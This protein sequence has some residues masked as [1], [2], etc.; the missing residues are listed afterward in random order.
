M[1][2]NTKKGQTG[3]FDLIVAVFIATIAIMALALSWDRSISKLNEKNEI[4][5]LQIKLYQ[6]SDLLITSEGN[7][8]EWDELVPGEN[9][10]SL[11]LAKKDRV[12]YKEKIDELYN[13]ELLNAG[14]IKEL[15]NI[16]PYGFQ[17]VVKELDGDVIQTIGTNP[18]QNSRVFIFTRYASLRE[19]E[20]V[21][22]PTYRGEPVEIITKIW[23]D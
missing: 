9:P 23:K 10:T 8:D 18:P 12:L 20:N 11:G 2:I 13:I 4:N 1:N 5:D 21:A 15:L 16:E 3:V 17:I 19:K 6:I 14:E 7:K 22:N